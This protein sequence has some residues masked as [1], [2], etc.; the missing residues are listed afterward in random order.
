MFLSKQEKAYRIRDSVWGAL[1]QHRNV[2]SEKQKN[3][4]LLNVYLLLRDLSLINSDWSLTRSGISLLQFGRSN[5][6]LYM[7][8]LTKCFLINANYIDILTMI[9][10]LNNQQSKFSNV[11]VLKKILENKIIKEKLATP[12]TNV[13]R[14]LQDILRILK[15]L[16]LITS[17]EKIDNGGRFNVNWRKIVPF[18][19]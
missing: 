11:G 16:D 9:Q 2:Q 13:E 6:E 8:E 3:A 14:D 4:W 1:K 17:W 7:K 12:K 5:K 15:E 18:L 19:K 10:E